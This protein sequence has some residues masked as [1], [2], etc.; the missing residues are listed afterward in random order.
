MTK[1]GGQDTKKRM[2][3]R[4]I[5]TNLSI[6]ANERKKKGVLYKILPTFS[7]YLSQMS[8]VEISPLRITN[9][10]K[11]LEKGVVDR[12]VC[13]RIRKA[14]CKHPCNPLLGHSPHPR[15]VPLIWGKID[16]ERGAQDNNGKRYGTRRNKS[17]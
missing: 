7:P 12:W 6:F 15:H 13:T 11:V 3:A 8:T 14:I 2:T 5:E 16:L 10:F 9:I 17:P 4:K 1:R